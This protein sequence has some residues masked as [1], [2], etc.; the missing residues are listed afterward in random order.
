MTEQ[1]AAA[2]P[3]P[4]LKEDPGATAAAGDQVD[5]TISIKV[6]GGVGEANLKFHL[7]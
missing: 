6:S 3:D 4:G 2:K 7:L 5:S 1:P